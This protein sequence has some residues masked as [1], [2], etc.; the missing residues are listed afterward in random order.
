MK[1]EDDELSQAEGDNP[2]AK[3]CQIRLKVSNAYIAG[4]SLHQIKEFLNRDFVCTRLLHEGSLEIPRG[5]TVIQKDDEL[6]IVCAEADAEAVQAFIGPIIDLPWEEEDTKQP[7][8]SKRIV[9][10]NSLSL[11]HIS[12]PTRLH[13]VSR[14]PSSA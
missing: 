8:I 2:N 5:E 14:M 1:D 10:T 4:R 12:E 7:M 6:L 3:P 13:K 9:I 11:I